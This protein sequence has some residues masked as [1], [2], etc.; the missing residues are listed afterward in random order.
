MESRMVDS[1]LVVF[2]PIAGYWLTSA[3]YY[4]TLGDK[5]DYR[6]FPKEEEDSRNIV[7]RRQVLVVVL[8]NQL[9]QM[10]LAWV[11]FAGGSTPIRAGPK[12]LLQVFGQLA[13]AI[14]FV[15]T[16]EYFWHRLMHQNKFLFKH[17]HEMHHRMMVPYAYGTLYAHPLDHFL[18]QI[19]G[20]Y[21]SFYLSGMSVRTA[22][23]FYTVLTIKAV[24]DHAS[25]WLPIHRILPNNSA[26]HALHHQQEGLKYNFSFPLLNVWD[27]LLG[28][29]LPFSVVERRGGGYEI[30]TA[31]TL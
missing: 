6:L 29:Y 12:S 26:H 8:A 19:M 11:L 28:T 27:K 2:M 24:D 20:S 4:V 21:L 14:L 30:R 25:Q 17:V 1:L 9:L 31:K 13:V 10:A 22:A 7:S 18:C 5:E 23:C 3:V 15:D 16:W